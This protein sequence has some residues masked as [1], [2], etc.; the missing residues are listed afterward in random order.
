MDEVRIPA[1]GDPFASFARRKPSTR[2][3][4]CD[5]RFLE[6]LEEDF[7]IRQF[8]LISAFHGCTRCS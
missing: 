8:A 6:L 4:R 5:H 1:A 7:G 2:R 3:H